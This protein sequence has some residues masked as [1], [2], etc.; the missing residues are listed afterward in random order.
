MSSAVP[1]ITNVNVPLDEHVT[2]QV[3][4]WPDNQ[5]KFAECMGLAHSTMARQYIIRGL[6]MDQYK[7]HPMQKYA[8]VAKKAAG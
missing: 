7:P 5:S 8:D 4:Y 6:V 1:S 2:P 3:V